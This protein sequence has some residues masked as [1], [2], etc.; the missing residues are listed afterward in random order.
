MKNPVELTIK[1]E[2][3]TVTWIIDSKGSI[4]VEHKI[5]KNYDVFNADSP[6]PKK[7]TRT[8]KLRKSN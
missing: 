5:S 6:K 4:S 1:D 2:Y 3:G 7:S 8:N